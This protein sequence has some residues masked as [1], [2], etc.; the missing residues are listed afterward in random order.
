MRAGRAALT[1]LVKGGLLCRNAVAGPSLPRVIVT[2]RCYRQT[3]PRYATSTTPH[4][5]WKDPALDEA[6]RQLE[7]GA[8][9]LEA[10]N[11]PE[12]KVG[13][14]CPLLVLLLLT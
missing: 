9:A 5:S 7:L 12:A 11:I 10:G 3:H 13:A 8:V 1:Q 4:S 6:Q 14:E 2:K